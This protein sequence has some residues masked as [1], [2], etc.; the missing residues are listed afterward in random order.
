M[1]PLVQDLASIDE[2]DVHTEQGRRSVTLLISRVRNGGKGAVEDAGDG[3]GLVGIE[4]LIR[5]SGRGRRWY[6]QN[7]K[8]GDEQDARC[9][10][11]EYPVSYRRVML[12]YL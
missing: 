4:K 5:S 6:L 7:G 12:E 9:E 2:F 3:G 10:R 1:T 8:K 11:P